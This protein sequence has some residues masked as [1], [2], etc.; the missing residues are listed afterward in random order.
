MTTFTY[1]EPVPFSKLFHCEDTTSS[2]PEPETPIAPCLPSLEDHEKS[3]P[4]GKCAVNKEEVVNK[5]QVRGYVKL[6]NDDE[7]ID[8]VYPEGTILYFKKRRS[9]TRESALFVK[10]DESCL[11]TKDGSFYHATTTFFVN[12]YCD[13]NGECTLLAY[14]GDIKAVNGGKTYT[15]RGHINVDNTTKPVNDRNAYLYDVVSV[16][17]GSCPQK[18]CSKY[19]V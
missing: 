3:T 12:H 7:R 14:Y 8:C 1:K 15:E 10:R 19:V 16:L 2:H 4:L 18:V 6:Y 5:L 17:D 11:K 13:Y 9:G